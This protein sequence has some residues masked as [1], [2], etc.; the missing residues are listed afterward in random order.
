M[1]RADQVVQFLTSR[2]GEDYWDDCIAK[3][4]TPPANRDYIQSK[5]NALGKTKSFDRGPRRCAACGRDKL[6]TKAL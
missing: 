4:L 6:V 1:Q 3:S 5:A 2:K